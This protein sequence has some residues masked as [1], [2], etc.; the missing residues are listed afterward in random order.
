MAE[1]ASAKIM[2]LEDRNSQEV[3]SRIQGQFPR[4]LGENWRSDFFRIPTVTASLHARRG[5]EAVPP[6]LEEHLI[7]FIQES[8]KSYAKEQVI[9]PSLRI[10]LDSIELRFR[11]SVNPQVY[12]RAMTLPSARE[13]LPDRG[14]MI[15]GIRIL[16]QGIKVSGLLLVFSLA[17]LGLDILAGLAGVFLSLSAGLFYLY[18]FWLETKKSILNPRYVTFGILAF[19]WLAFLS[20]L[21]L[22]I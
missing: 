15:P 4:H 5:I 22:L 9:H 20:L 3:S 16:N 12:Y 18:A 10:T 7:R 2:S 14:A 17:L 11:V 6:A 13:A 21:G 1:I 8:M 19:V